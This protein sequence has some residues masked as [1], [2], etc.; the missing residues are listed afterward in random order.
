[1]RM[2]RVHGEYSIRESH[3]EAMA[4]YRKPRKPICFWKS[5]IKP[6]DRRTAHRERQVSLG[7]NAK[8]YDSCIVLPIVVGIRMPASERDSF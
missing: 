1:M 4:N 7:E 5:G 6:S 3:V 8:C 2:M